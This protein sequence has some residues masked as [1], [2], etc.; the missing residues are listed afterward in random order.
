M[1]DET[2]IEKDLRLLLRAEFATFKLELFRE[3]Q[4]KLDAKADVAQLEAV[5]KELGDLKATVL[6]LL[7][8]GE[9]ERAREGGI[10]Y[11]LGRARALA[12]WAAALAIATVDVII[13]NHH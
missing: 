5:R 4:V 6:S 9:V 12:G 11:T 2:S 8:A 1:S 3:L 13:R 7:R 10:W